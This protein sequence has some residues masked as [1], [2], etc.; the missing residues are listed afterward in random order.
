MTK[1]I[2]IPAGTRFG[3]LV[4]VGEGTPAV[5][6]SGQIRRRISCTCD[7]G[8]KLDVHLDSLRR[9]LS[10][11]CGCFKA[12]RASETQFKHGQSKP[13]NM[14][15]RLWSNIKTR[16]V[17]GTGANSHRYIGRG[18]TMYA[19]WVNDFSAF[20]CW[21]AESLGKRPERYSINRIDNNKGYE[22][23]NLEWAS[24]KEQTNNTSKNV[25]VTYGSDTLT[26]AQWAERTGVDRG[27]LWYRLRKRNW[28]VEKALTTPVRSCK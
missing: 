26:L 17:S 9:G 24:Q 3:R 16:A 28:P 10:Q 13:G 27:T 5:L 19:P 7:C 18:I 21:I 11:S 8:A 22:P 6:P 14:L 4:A 15:Y 12:E 1:K 23:G 2:E 25:F 20:S